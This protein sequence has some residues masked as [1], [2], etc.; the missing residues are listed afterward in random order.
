MKKELDEIKKIEEDIEIKIESIKNEDKEEKHDINKVK[1]LKNTIYDKTS[2]V[3]VYNLKKLIQLEGTQK[4]LAKK[5]GVSE[6]LLSK[7]KTEEAFPSIET[8]MY[9]CKIYN[10]SLD[11]FLNRT[12][13]AMDIENLENNQGVDEEIF[14]EKYYAY[15][16]ITNIGKE[17]GIHEGRIEFRNEEV[18]FKILSMGEVVKSFKG[19]YIISEKLIFFNLQSGHDGIAYINMIK[20][21]LN[22]NKYIGG[23]ALMML[24]SDANSKPCVQK[25]L[26]SKTRIDREEH[27]GELKRFLNFP[28][29]GK[30]LGNVKISPWEDE[31]VYDFISNY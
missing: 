7:Y 21:N 22:K 15:F 20:P 25:I 19:S 6:D 2:K 11:K 29:K 24:P 30:E 8:L 9:I 13:T 28:E 23:L 5:I 31:E 10:L 17:G 16:L 27:K 4:R 14:E 3:F 18:V 12:L 1:V 26:I